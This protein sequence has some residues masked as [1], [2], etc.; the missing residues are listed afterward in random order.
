MTLDPMIST[1]P[2]ME[3]ARLK[4]GLSGKTNYSR[5]WIAK[6]SVQDL[7]GTH[8]LKGFHKVKRKLPLTRLPLILIYI[9]LI[10]FNEV[11][12]EM[13]KHAFPAYTF[14][15]QKRYMR[16]HLIKPR[17]MK[18]CSFISRLQELNAYLEE[19]PPDTE[20]QETAPL[21]ANEIKDII[22]HPMPI[23]WKIRWL[24]KV[25]ISQNLPSKKWQISLKPGLKTCS[26]RKK[27]I[28]FLFLVTQQGRN[29]IAWNFSITWR[30]VKQQT[31]PL[32]T[33]DVMD[34]IYHSM[35]TTWKNKMM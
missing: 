27:Q 31:A 7:Y 17:S 1:S 5:P 35:L 34:I 24:N 18:L 12:L 25:S 26:S 3:E 19:F 4:S 11:L 10:K 16:K 8:S 30:A 28:H 14:R 32:P 13:T 22:Y 15:K 33:D 6:A 29:P 20:G 23:M 21:T 9:L 2:S